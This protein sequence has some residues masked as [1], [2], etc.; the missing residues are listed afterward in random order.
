MN[1]SVVMP[2]YNEEES[3]GKV[4]QDIKR[5]TTDFNTEILIVDSSKD[6][7]PHV[8]KALGVSVITQPPQ[9]HGFALHA[10]LEAASGD[11]IIT[12]DCDDTYPMEMIS[13]LLNLMTEKNLDVISCNRITP[14][15]D[16]EMSKRN[17]I[18]NKLAALTVRLLYRIETHDVATGMF[19]LRKS[20][21]EKLNLKP[22]P[23]LPPE[24][25]IQTNVKGLNYLE[26][27]IPY[28]DRPGRSTL[29]FSYAAKEYMRVI[30]GLLFK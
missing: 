25:I 29:N 26:V 24:I 18:G 15:L 21:V 28:R 19:C 13:E 5:H 8:A 11:Y 17:Q 7:T 20:V 27:D 6:K 23:A 16:K 14:S 1:I 9:G 4:V 10:A 30:F 2:T 22:Y 3:V 12:A